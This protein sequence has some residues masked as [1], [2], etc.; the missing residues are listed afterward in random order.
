MTVCTCSSFLLRCFVFLPMCSALWSFPVQLSPPVKRNVWGHVS[1]GNIS[2][3]VQLLDDKEGRQKSCSAHSTLGEQELRRFMS[4]FFVLKLFLHQRALIRTFPQEAVNSWSSACVWPVVTLGKVILSLG[5]FKINLYF[6]LYGSAAIWKLARSTVVSTTWLHAKPVVSQKS[7]LQASG[8][9]KNTA[10]LLP[11]RQP[12]CGTT[13]KTI[14]SILLP[15][16]V[17]RLCLEAFVMVFCAVRVFLER[18]LWM[19][20]DSWSCTIA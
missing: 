9:L 18:T 15:I 11:I 12:S 7:N 6:H 10:A 20:K 5:G 13:K 14:Q 8:R 2:F 4:S 16:W 3:S 19:T 1:L 17:S